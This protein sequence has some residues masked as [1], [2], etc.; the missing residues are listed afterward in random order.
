PE[1][2]NYALLVANV[3]QFAKVIPQR[4]AIYSD[5]N[6]VSLNANHG[7]TEVTGVGTDADSITLDTAL[8]AFDEVDVL[9]CDTE[10]SEFEIFGA[11]SWH[12][13]QKIKY[14]T[15]EFHDYYGVSRRNELLDKFA[16]THDMSSDDFRE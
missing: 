7:L 1:P 4:L 12:T 2:E 5:A 3:T 8:E 14:I 13:M 9:K 16:Q 10:G 15:L 6:G 11:A